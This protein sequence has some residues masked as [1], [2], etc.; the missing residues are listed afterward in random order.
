MGIINSMISDGKD[1][2][3][4]KT[5]NACP[6]CGVLPGQPHQRNCDVE[7]CSACGGQRLA[8]DC[9]DHDPESAYW[10][11]EWPGAAECRRR[12]WYCALIPGRGW[13]PCAADTAQAQE[14][15]N[16]LCF[17]QANGFDGLYETDGKT[18]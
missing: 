12:G 13:R 15:L 14:D 4:S 8:C 18:R 7:R 11:G 9:A 5:L 3:D 10:T 17:F 2:S 6:G 1:M 16:R